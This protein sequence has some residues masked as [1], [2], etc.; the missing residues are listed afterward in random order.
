MDDRGYYDDN[1]VS[2]SLVCD[3]CDIAPTLR[4]SLH[5]FAK[6]KTSGNPPAVNTTGNCKPGRASPLDLSMARVMGHLIM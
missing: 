2:D 6:P 5:R 3:L 4:R 1:D